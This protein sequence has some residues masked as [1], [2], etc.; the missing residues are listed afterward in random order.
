MPQQ[1]TTL[2]HISWLHRFQ[3]YFDPGHAV[4]A[5]QKLLEGLDPSQDP[6]ATA[7]IDLAAGLL[8]QALVLNPCDPNARD[9]LRQLLPMAGSSP[10]FQAWFA[11]LPRATWLVTKHK[12]PVKTKAGSIITRLRTTRSSRPEPPKIRRTKKGRAA[13]KLQSRFIITSG[14]NSSQKSRK[15]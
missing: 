6:K 2:D 4:W 11:A 5:A 10:D 9:L 8:R 13:V 7:R 15:L 1:P 14:T 12:A 3:G